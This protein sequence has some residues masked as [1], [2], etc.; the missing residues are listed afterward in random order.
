MTLLKSA[1]WCRCGTNRE[2][3]SVHD[4]SKMSHRKWRATKHHPSRATSGH[5]ISCF[6]VSLH[7]LCDILSKS[8]CI[9]FKA[10]SYSH[11]TEM[12]YKAVLPTYYDLAIS[13]HV[14]EIADTYC[15]I[16]SSLSCLKTSCMVGHLR[17]STYLR[18]NEQEGNVL[19]KVPAARM[20][21]VLCGKQVNF[22][23]A[24]LVI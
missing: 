4:E 19:I 2:L 14:M 13:K 11:D 24:K 10:V 9:C 3:C 22:E 1:T 21:Q 7:F 8:P 17:T 15:L 16:Y 5:Q 12:Q 20:I 6:L 23:S 18:K